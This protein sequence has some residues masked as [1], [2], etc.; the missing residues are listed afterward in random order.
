MDNQTQIQIE[1][2][3]FYHFESVKTKTKEQ[4]SN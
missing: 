2:I 3:R 4:L 1:F